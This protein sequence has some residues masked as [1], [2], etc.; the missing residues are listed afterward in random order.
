MFNNF[1]AICDLTE[2]EFD[3]MEN[4]NDFNYVLK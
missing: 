3:E 4:I 2:E 1:T